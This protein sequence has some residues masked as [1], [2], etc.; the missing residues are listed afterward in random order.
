MSNGIQNF[1][2]VVF[3]LKMIYL[4]FFSHQQLKLLHK[5]MMSRYGKDFVYIEIYLQ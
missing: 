1:K 5:E 2:N 3:S 4:A